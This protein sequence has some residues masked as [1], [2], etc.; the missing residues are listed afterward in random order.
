MRNIFLILAVIYVFSVKSSLL[1]PKSLAG[2]AFR[3]GSAIEPVMAR[4]AAIVSVFG[5]NRDHI[6]LQTRLLADIVPDTTVSIVQINSTRVLIPSSHV[7]VGLVSK[8][9]LRDLEHT[10]LPFV[11][12]FIDEVVRRK[13]ASKLVLL[14]E[15]DE[16]TVAVRS[17][18]EDLGA[19]IANAVSDDGAEAA[20]L[21]DVCTVL[22]S[23]TI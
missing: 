13:T 4:K 1:G 8:Y 22:S 3:G 17:L 2:D 15:S 19:M 9:S 20:S 16:K 18:V 6:D 7:V 5:F 12:S 21:L 11:Q 14:I 10:T 23:F